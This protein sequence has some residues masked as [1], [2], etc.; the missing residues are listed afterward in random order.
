MLAEILDPFADLTPDQN[1]VSFLTKDKRKGS[2]YAR[3][4]A[5]ACR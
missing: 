1:L 5:E 3:Y 2:V 4:L